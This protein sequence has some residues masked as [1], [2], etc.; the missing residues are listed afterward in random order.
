MAIKYKQ[1]R[2]NIWVI[3]LTNNKKQLYTDK[4]L[5][6]MLSNDSD[7]RKSILWK[8][9]YHK[10]W[11]FTDDEDYELLDLPS[12]NKVDWKEYFNVK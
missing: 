12:P 8:L 11:A 9:L 1:T 3:D 10:Y 4:E 5:I 6:K 7:I 2:F